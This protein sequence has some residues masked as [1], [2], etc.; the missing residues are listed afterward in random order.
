[1][2]DK[3]EVEGAI[4]LIIYT[5]GTRDVYHNKEFDELLESIAALSRSIEH[6]HFDVMASEFGI[7]EKKDAG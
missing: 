6:G 4:N 1:M 2:L 3:K 7:K 5:Y